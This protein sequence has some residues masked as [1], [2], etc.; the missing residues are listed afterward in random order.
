MAVRSRTQHAATGIMIELHMV[1]GPGEERLV[2]EHDEDNELG[3]GCKVMLHLL[4][5]WTSAKCHIVCADS[6]FASVQAACCL[7]DLN[8]RFVG[9]VKMVTKMFG[10]GG[11]TQLWECGSIDNSS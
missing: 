11:V 6:Y 2:L 7:F 8:F 1:E 9:V 10:K 5:F 3:H 4:Q